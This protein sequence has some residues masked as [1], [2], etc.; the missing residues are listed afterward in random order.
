[1]LSDGLRLQGYG[2]ALLSAWWQFHRTARI[3]AAAN[4][5]FDKKY[6]R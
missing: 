3:N 4:I 5:L 6:W 1:M 2:V